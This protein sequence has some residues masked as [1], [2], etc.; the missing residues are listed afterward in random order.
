[1]TNPND[2]VGTNAAYGGRTSTNAFNDL[3]NAFTRGIVSGWECVP[4]TG[5]TVSL[6]GDGNNRDVAIAIDNAGN[7]TTINNISQSPVDVTLD[8]APVSNSRI[9]SIVAYVDNPANGVS[10]VADN[11]SA[12]GLIAV[13]GTV[14]ANPVAPNESTIR[15][16]ITADGASGTTAYYVVLANITIANGTTDITS[17]DIAQGSIISLSGNKVVKSNNIDL[18][19]LSSNYSESE[20]D[21]GYTWID[22]KHIYKKTVN[23]GSGPNVNTK[24]VSS[25]ITNMDKLINIEAMAYSSSGV[26]SIAPSLVTFF[27]DTLSIGQGSWYV[28]YNKGT[29]NISVTAAAN[30]TDCTIYVTLYYTKTS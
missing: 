24:N 21:T 23:F 7:R 10:T 1:M 13:K 20:I 4:N 29:N 17:G 22:G 18:S 30:R 26:F 14:A 25:G 19:T 28:G 5:L 6:G 8:A 12:C 15:T 27:P 11:P 2:A 9:D 16:A 3:A